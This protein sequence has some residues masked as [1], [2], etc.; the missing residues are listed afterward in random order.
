MPHTEAYPIQK[1]PVYTLDPLEDSRWIQLI[2]QHPNASVFHSR[3]WL[4]A[5][6]ATY[7]YEPI[8]FTT[9]APSEPLTNGL[10]FCVVRSWLTNDRLVSLPFSDHCEPLVTSSQEFTALTTFVEEACRTNK[11]GYLEIRS[12][13][14]FLA[15]DHG[16]RQTVSYTLHRLDLRPDLNELYGRLHKS[17]IRR[18]I[19]RAVREGLTYE[20]GNSHSLLAHL[21]HLVCITRARHR[22]PPQPIKWFRNLCAA[23][24]TNACIRVAFKEGQPVA[25]SLT[26]REGKHL[27]YKYGASD[28]VFNQ[29]G[30]MPMLIWETIKEAKQEGVESLDLGR[31][32]LDNPGLII[33]KERWGAECFTLTTW[34]APGQCPLPN[35][36]WW[37]GQ[38]ARGLFSRMPKRV[39]ALAGR[40]L[41]RHVG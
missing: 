2:G 7:G 18:K 16:F 30:G 31:S 24:G 19:Q 20:A 27:V 5:L 9:S 32:D 21:Y 10:L 17:C 35:R 36:E 13:D 28:T 8:V 25:G 39:Q 15:F 26:L 34:Q 23:M 41:Y 40:L 6:W 29:S 37:I 22:L 14:P 38:Q 33:F 11:W 12:A 1:T 3:S 4:L